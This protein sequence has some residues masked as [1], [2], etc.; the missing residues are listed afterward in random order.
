MSDE[1][2]AKSRE[3]QAPKSRILAENTSTTTP[4]ANM[5][6]REATQMVSGYLD[7]RVRIDITPPAVNVKIDL[8]LTIISP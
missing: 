6:R 2:P 7:L 8:S 4:S 3:A 1:H 5:V